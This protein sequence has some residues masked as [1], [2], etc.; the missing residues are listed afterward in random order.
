MRPKEVISKYGRCIELI[1]MDPFFNEVTIGLFFKEPLI[2]VY[3]YSKKDGLED[4]L[5][6]IR[7]R[8]VD[9]AGALPSD[10][11]NQATF[12]CEMKDGCC[13]SPL[14]FVVK[15]AVMKDRPN[16]ISNGISHK[17]LRSDMILSINHSLKD[18]INT[19]TVSGDGNA[20]KP[21]IRYRA[22]VNGLLKYGGFEKIDNFSFKLKCNTRNDKLINLLLPLARNISATEESLAADDMAG[23]MTTQS[24]GFA[25]N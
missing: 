6:Q 20:P 4:R 9:I 22:V 18:G 19:Y 15:E 21:E 1:S 13:S 23:Q 8:I 24:L 2:T 25:A 11:F 10:N 16:D 14:R 7:D 17:D 5:K 3:S 12:P